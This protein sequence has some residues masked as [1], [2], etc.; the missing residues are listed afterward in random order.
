MPPLPAG[1][2]TALQFGGGKDSLAI[3]HLMRPHWSDLVVVWMNPGAA[4]PEVEAQMRE[5]AALV[6]HFREI[7]ADV[8]SDI[9]ENGWPVDVVPVRSTALGK[10]YRGDDGGVLLRSWL[11]C[12]ARNFWAPMEAQMRAWGIKTIIRGQ[13]AS[14]DW[15]NPHAQNG[16]VHDGVRYL[17]PIQG[18]SEADVF[19]YLDRI[20]VKPPAYYETLPSSLDCWLCTAYLDTKTPQIGY[21]RERHPERHKIVKRVIDAAAAAVRAGGDEMKRAGEV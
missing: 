5:I 4:F 20:G 8:V 3:L 6:P 18:W 19:A 12:C 15:K 16:V 11:D 13:R 14:E 10:L 21:L 1:V 9:R 17:L 2:T 7:R